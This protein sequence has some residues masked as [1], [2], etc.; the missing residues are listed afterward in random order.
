MLMNLPGVYVIYNKRIYKA[1]LVTKALVEIG[2]VEI[3]N[4]TAPRTPRPETRRYN[5]VRLVYYV[6]PAGYRTPG[7]RLK[8]TMQRVNL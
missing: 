3:E 1:M 2:V 8:L 5:I 7:L 6:D 4:L